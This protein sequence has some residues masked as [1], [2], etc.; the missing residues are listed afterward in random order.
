VL[1]GFKVHNI[2][3]RVYYKILWIL[4]DLNKIMA[5]IKYEFSTDEYIVFLSKK[6]GGP[7]LGEGRLLGILR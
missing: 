1:L 6:P 3:I 7:L 5:L 2:H 4:N